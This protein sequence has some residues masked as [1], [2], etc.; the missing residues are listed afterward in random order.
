M[1]LN[2]KYVGLV[3]DKFTKGNAKHPVAHTV[4]ELKKIL[5]ELPG[6]LQINHAF[7]C[8]VVV[9]VYNVKY[10]DYHVEF[11]ENEE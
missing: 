6:D 1:N 5:D 7:S 2:D 3:P 9:V 8:G 11:C 10:D 4:K